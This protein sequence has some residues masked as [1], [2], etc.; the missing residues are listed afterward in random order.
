[1][2]NILP[3]EE[4]K[5]IL[6]E[7]RLRLAV[8]A[9]FAISIL[10]VINLILLV[11]PYLL[12]I[13]KNSSVANDLAAKQSKQAIGG[14]DKSIEAQIRGINKKVSVFLGSA[15]S[16]PRLSP[17]D[18]ILKIIDMKDPTIKILGFDYDINGQQERFAISGIA[19][20]RDGLA[21]FVDILKRD[22]TF[23][24]V[25]LPVSSYVKSANI[26]FTIM[27]TRGVVGTPVK[28]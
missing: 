14:Q 3:T 25:D 17:P 19:A 16:T 24:T 8:V 18:A 9:V 23:T 22:S 11:P 6:K 20:D 5:G 1:M 26:S 2:L 15:T 21:R 27:T 12:V 13:S 4:K 10:V 28:K 7:Y